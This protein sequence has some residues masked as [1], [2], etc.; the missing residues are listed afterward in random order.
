MRVV[1]LL[2]V[3][4]VAGIFVLERLQSTEVASTPAQS[5]PEAQRATTS[6]GPS[7]SPS[8]I[9][10][11][12]VSTSADPA[13]E[14]AAAF[15]AFRS[16]LLAR[17]GR[18]AAS[19]VTEG[20]LHYYDQI[21]SMVL[22]AEKPIVTSQPVLTQ[23]LVLHLRDRL[24]AYQLR[25]LSGRHLFSYAVDEG[26][27]GRDIGDF[28]VSDIKVYAATASATVVEGRSKGLTVEFR[29]ESDAWKLNLVPVLEFLDRA[30][31]EVARQRGLS[32]EEFVDA[33]VSSESGRP[34]MWNPPR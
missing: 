4:A 1:V 30:V 14:V 31:S 20:T 23:L 7:A 8:R 32:N 12:P 24:S 25:E 6:P 22:T 28:R 16:G 17:N 3:L 10:T 26:L 19:A 21:A 9:A 5:S 27:A 29:R 13:A 2:L 15:E 11:R 18:L 33:V 34:P